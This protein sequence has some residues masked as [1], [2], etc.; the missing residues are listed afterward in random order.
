MEKT[1]ELNVQFNQRYSYFKQG[2]EEKKSALDIIKQK[3]ITSL[4]NKGFGPKKL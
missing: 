3:Y 2:M 1:I 4:H